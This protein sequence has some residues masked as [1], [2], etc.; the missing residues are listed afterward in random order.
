MIQR[1][2]RETLMMGR[3]KRRIIMEMNWKEMRA[4]DMHLIRN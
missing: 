1:S 2:R 4:M 3:M